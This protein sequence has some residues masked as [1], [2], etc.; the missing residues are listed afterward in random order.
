MEKYHSSWQQKKSCHHFNMRTKMKTLLHKSLNVTNHATINSG[1][2]LLSLM[3]FLI[4][5]S[6]VSTRKNVIKILIGI[7]NCSTSHYIWIK[8]KWYMLLFKVKVMI[9][10]RLL[11]PVFSEHWTKLT[12]C[13][14]GQFGWIWWDNI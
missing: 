11:Y 9:K 2:V 14:H 7:L 3:T 12:W 10:K 13:S 8:T 1:L 4:T 6:L 5:Q